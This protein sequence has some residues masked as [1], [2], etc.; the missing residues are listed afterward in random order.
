MSKSPLEEQRMD[1][2]SLLS[3]IRKKQAIRDTFH[4]RDSE[5]KSFYYS[6]KIFLSFWLA[7]STSIIHLNQLL[8]TKFGR[9]LRLIDRWQQKCRT[10][11]QVNAPLTKKTW[12]RGWAGRNGPTVGGTFHSFHH[13]LLSKNIARRQLD[14]QHLLFGVYLLTWTSLCLLNMHYRGELNIDKG[15]H[16]L[17]CF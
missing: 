12:G 5:F 11:V 3:E 10:L 1:W 13:E 9:I 15:K 2:W 8:L 17:A 14:G 6:F 7:K 16:V 4:L